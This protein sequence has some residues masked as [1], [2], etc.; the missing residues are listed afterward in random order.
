MYVDCCCRRFRNRDRR[1]P[2]RAGLLRSRTTVGV[3]P[4]SFLVRTRIYSSRFCGGLLV[5]IIDLPLSLPSPTCQKLYH[6]CTSLVV[7]P[8]TT[9]AKALTTTLNGNVYGIQQAYGTTINN[10]NKKQES[11][12]RLDFLFKKVWVLHYFSVE[13]LPNFLL[14]CKVQPAFLIARFLLSSVLY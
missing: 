3:L 7:V 1:I 2:P 13:R 9:Y 12:S 14:S 11:C 10:K 5:G 8:K 6:C 4:S